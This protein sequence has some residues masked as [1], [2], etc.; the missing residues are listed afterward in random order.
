MIRKHSNISKSILINALGIQSNH[1]IINTITVDVIDYS[2]PSC[3][4]C[5]N[6]IIQETFS[7][8]N[9]RYKESHNIC[10]N[11]PHCLH[12][13]KQVE[14]VEYINEKN[15]Y[16][17]KPMLKSI[18]IKLLILL[19]MLGP[20]SEGIVRN[21]S[22]KQMS[23]E[24]NCNRRTILNN[25]DVL[26]E[27]GYICY[28]KISCDL[29]NIIILDYNKT[30]L[31]ANKGG[32]G[33]F[34]VSDELFREL[35]NL[36]SLVTLRIFLRTLLELDRT[37][38]S[39][40]TV[41]DSRNIKDIRRELPQYCKPCVILSNLHSNVSPIFDISMEKSNVIR[42]ELKDRY[43]VKKRLEDINNQYKDFIFKFIVDF[44]ADIFSLKSANLSQPLNNEDII[45]KNYI[46][47]DNDNYPLFPLA[48]LKKDLDDLASLCT[49]YSFEHVTAAL[50][51]YYYS[52]LLKGRTIDNIPGYIHT[53]I[54]NSLNSNNQTA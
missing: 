43:N 31:P 51:T 4:G 28:D 52:A 10:E 8:N 12:T 35:V 49:T 6:K 41:I 23:K 27:Y 5:I 47:D 16:G 21:A 22:V 45:N 19:H 50:I 17:Y 20:S 15:K 34:M 9:P 14:K 48:E 26:Q 37:N 1:K 2:S 18:A 32:R 29:F 54:K 44:N 36:N 11:C 39:G 25:L 7:E 40:H 53:I 33:Y 38:I 24:L 46:P 3:A 13:T 42:F 30:Y